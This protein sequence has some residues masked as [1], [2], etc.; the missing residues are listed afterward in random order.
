[1][2]VWFSRFLHDAEGEIYDQLQ[3]LRPDYSKA[4]GQLRTTLERSTD[5]KPDGLAVLDIACGTGSATRL[6]CESKRISRNKFA[7]FVGI[8][9]DPKLLQ[10]AQAKCPDLEICHAD[11]MQAALQTRFDFILC[12]FAYHHVPDKQKATLC[13]KMRQWCKD[14]GDLFAL[15]ICLTADQVKPYYE[16]LKAALPRSGVRRLCE[17]FLDW[18]MSADR[19]T[20]GEWKVPLQQVIQDFTQAGW[21]PRS[22]T[23][24]W[25]QQP[26][27]KDAGCFLLHFTPA[28]PTE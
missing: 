8:D 18:T 5:T 26:G 24:I 10:L 3:W 4:M 17:V 19:N 6:I 20:T 11:M 1:M 15:E 2:E 12:S 16:R 21:L 22:V 23:P 9:T 25:A 7:K 13:S 14:D 28:A 27:T